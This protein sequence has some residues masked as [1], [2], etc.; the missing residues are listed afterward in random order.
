M[1]KLWPLALLVAGVALAGELRL[2]TNGCTLTSTAPTVATSADDTDCTWEP[3]VWLK[4]QCTAAVYYSHDGTTPT[5][6]S[7]KLT[8][9]DA[10]PIRARQRSAA[11][12]SDAP[13]R[14]LPVSGAATCEVFK[15]DGNGN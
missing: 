5:S 3:G 9:G 10:Y 7:P 2:G 15:D 6:K 12:V 11:G 4:L 1:R 8:V 13:V 14:T